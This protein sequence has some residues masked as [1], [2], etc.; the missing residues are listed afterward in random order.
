MARVAGIG[1]GLFILSVIWVVSLF[2]CITLSRAPGSL[3]NAGAGAIVLAI[4]VTLIL[5]FFPKEDDTTVV[6]YAV[7]DEYG[8]G[9][10]ALISILGIF[11]LIGLMAYLIF[12]IFEPQRTNRLN[13]LKTL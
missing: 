9:R 8:V 6:D 12:H 11:L 13:K 3:A 4:L 5:V 1:V 10:T 2:A 7:Y